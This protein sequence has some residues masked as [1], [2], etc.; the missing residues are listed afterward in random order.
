MPS[1][2]P[3]RPVP[4]MRLRLL[5]APALTPPDGQRSEL[6]RKD[7]AFLALLAVDGPLPR[8]RVAASVRCHRAP[9]ELTADAGH[10]A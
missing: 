2:P 3:R 5:A 4:G 8:A 10:A 6:E 1:S 9:A 7:A